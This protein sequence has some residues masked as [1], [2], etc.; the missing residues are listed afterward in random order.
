[1]LKFCVLR[2]GL[3]GPLLIAGCGNAVET[4]AGSGSGGAN[5]ASTGTSGTASSGA[6]GSSSSVSTSASSS[7]GGATSSGSGGSG[8]SF[9]GA[10]SSA[11]VHTCTEIYAGDSAADAS[12]VSQYEM[13][14]KND[15]NYAWQ[16]QPCSSTGRV[17]AC[18]KTVQS[19]P[20]QGEYA[21]QYAYAGADSPSLELT[22]M[23]SGGVWQ[24]I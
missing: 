6:A 24:A 1:M 8:T 12:A 14:C 2:A 13:A 7:S 22:C 15:P 21:I 10:C 4:S 16:A 5:S 11:T 17:G 19:G 18:T 3:L 23:Q 9:K 20:T